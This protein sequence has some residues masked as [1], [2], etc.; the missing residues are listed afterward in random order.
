MSTT[1]GDAEASG[2]SY[3]GELDEEG[4][5][6]TL[7]TGGARLILETVNGDVSVGAR[8]TSASG[9]VTPD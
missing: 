5:E 9:P 8:S 7:G 1:N 6:I 2:L 4:G 3:S